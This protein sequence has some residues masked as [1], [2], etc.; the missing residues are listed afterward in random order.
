MGAAAKDAVNAENM[1]KAA[2]AAQN[3]KESIPDPQE[4]PSQDKKEE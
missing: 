2:A 4:E 1:M 3:I